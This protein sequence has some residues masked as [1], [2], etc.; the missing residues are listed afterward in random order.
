MMYTGKYTFGQIILYLF[1]LKHNEINF[2]LF[3]INATDH[4]QDHV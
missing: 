2:P 3:G 1:Q 4:F